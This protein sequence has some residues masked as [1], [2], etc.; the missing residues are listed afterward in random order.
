M[1]FVLLSIFENISNYQLNEKTHQNE[2]PLDLIINHFDLQ[3][4]E[5]HRDLIEIQECVKLLVGTGHTIRQKHINRAKKLIEEA[6][7]HNQ[8]YVIQDVMAYLLK[9]KED[10]KRKLQNRKNNKQEDNLTF[11]ISQISQP[12]KVKDTSRAR[13]PN[14]QSLQPS[15]DLFSCDINTLTQ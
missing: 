12:S 9:V 14:K 11:S 4:E 15:E 13:G 6:G 8:T 2:D 7:D 1:S 3:F 5:Q 10:R